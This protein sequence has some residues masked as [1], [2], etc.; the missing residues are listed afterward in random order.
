MT[1]SLF[2]TS[3]R[4]FAESTT[5]TGV[6]TGQV[7]ELPLVG[8]AAARRV[9]AWET[10]LTPFRQPTVRAPLHAAFAVRTS[11]EANAWLISW[12]LTRHMTEDAGT[13]YLDRE[14]PEPTFCLQMET[15]DG[16]LVE[17]RGMAL[18]ELQVSV[19]GRRVVTVEC[20]WAA[21]SRAADVALRAT[22]DANETTLVP[23]STVEAALVAGSLQPDPADDAVPAYSAE[24]FVRRPDLRQ[25]NYQPDGQP[26][27][28]TRSPWRVVGELVGPWGSLADTAAQQL[29]GAIALLIP[30]V[31]LVCRSVGAY[32]TNE[33]I[34]ADDF[35]DA[36]FLI[37]SAGDSRGSLLE[38]TTS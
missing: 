25:V 31:T 7:I 36:A 20:T 1:E 14:A 2:A 26:D 33:A 38:L 6:P 17:F 8:A 30:G 12:L 11:H 5:G 28:H 21:L 9:I 34:K 23:S 10:Q 37:E 18:Q 29:T 15:E 16:D 32:V 13:Y 24:L 35:R 19:T 27:G 4:F 3:T 22:T